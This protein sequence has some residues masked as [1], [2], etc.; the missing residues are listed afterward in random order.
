MWMEKCYLLDFVNSQDTQERHRRVSLG[1][2][3]C[4]GMDVGMVVCGEQGWCGV[5]IVVFSWCLLLSVYLVVV[6]D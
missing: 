2:I 5:C 3:I 1:V 4:V 6:H